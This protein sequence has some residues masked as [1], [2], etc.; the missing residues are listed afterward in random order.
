MEKSRARARESN[1]RSAFH[2]S[3]VTETRVAFRGSQSAP[4]RVVL[5]GALAVG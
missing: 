2:S 1:T 5:E 4:W 3:Y